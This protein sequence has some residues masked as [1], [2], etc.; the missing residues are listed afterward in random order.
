M[1]IDF[2]KE[3]LKRRKQIEIIK[4]PIVTRIYEEN[5]EIKYEI[6]DYIDTPLTWIK[7]CEKR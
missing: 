1:I 3:R 5:G 7:E 2:N 6:S 4:V